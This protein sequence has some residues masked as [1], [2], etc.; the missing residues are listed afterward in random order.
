[1][2]PRDLIQFPSRYPGKVTKHP[3]LCPTVMEALD[4]VA[5]IQVCFSDK[6]LLATSLCTEQ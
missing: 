3:V 4:A 6:S 2:P 5:E 1:M